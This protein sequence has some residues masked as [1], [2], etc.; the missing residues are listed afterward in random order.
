MVTY[1]VPQTVTS[2]MSVKCTRRTLRM[3][4]FTC[5]P[6]A[7]PSL[8]NYPKWD[9]NFGEPTHSHGTTNSDKIFPL[10]PPPPPPKYQTHTLFDIHV[11]SN[12]IFPT[13]KMNIVLTLVGLPQGANRELLEVYSN[14]QTGPLPGPPGSY[15]SGLSAHNFNQIK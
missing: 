9:S 11:N 12:N 14:P 10:P 1:M 4:N 3:P 6:H 13:D 15:L 7:Q 2:Y 8:S 5:A